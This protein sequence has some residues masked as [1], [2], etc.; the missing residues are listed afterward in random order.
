MKK[1]QWILVAAVISFSGAAF[2]DDTSGGCGIGWEVAKKQSLVSTLTRATTNSFLPNTFSMTF[3]TSGCAKHT[4][5]KNDEKAVYFAVNNKDTLITEI[6]QGQGEYLLTFAH[7]L[8][9]KDGD[10]ARFT[11]LTQKNYD[12]ILTAGTT[13]G[14][15]LYRAIRG[16]MLK[17]GV[18]SKSCTPTTAAI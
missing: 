5:V 11:E 17:D 7:A 16:E 8:G 18:L 10:I 14:I 12:A 1:T 15:Q 13:D 2:A 9:C 3:G 6:A 4:I